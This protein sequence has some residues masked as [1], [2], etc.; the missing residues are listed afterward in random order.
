M[1]I[2][3]TRAAA[4]I[5]DQIHQKCNKHLPKNSMV[6]CDNFVRSDDMDEYITL[7]DNFINAMPLANFEDILSCINGN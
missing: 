4:D 1:S 2:T 5:L 7:I 6:L 3:T